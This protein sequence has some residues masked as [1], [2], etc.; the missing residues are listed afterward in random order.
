MALRRRGANGDGLNAWPG[1]VDAL[2]TLLMVI[3]F[4]LL[5][6]V[7]AQAFLSVALSGRDQALD[8]LNRQVA[9]LSDMLSLERGRTSELQLSLA[10]VNNDLASVASARDALAQQVAALRRDQD[11]LAADRDALRT[12]RDRLSAKLADAALQSQTAQ[13]RIEDLTGQLA[14]A[15]KRA[16]TQSLDVSGQLG[17]AR[18]QLTARTA[19][20]ADAKRQLQAAQAQL[21]E[22]QRQMAELDRTVKADKATIEAKLSDLAK[23][24]EQIRTLTA[25]RDDLE[26]QAAAAAAR[27]TTEAQQRAAVAAQLDEEKKLGD[28]AKARIALLSR[29]VDEL[30]AQLASIQKALDASESAGKE[31]DA[32]ITDLGNRLNTALARKVEEL[33]R[34]RS[35]FF[36]RLRAVL[37]NRPGIQVVGDRFVF[38]SEVL[39]PVAS[40]DLTPAGVEQISKLAD[41][42]KQISAEI[43]ADVNWVLRVD[44][45]A[46]RQKIENSRWGSNWELSAGRAITVV[47]LLIADGIPPTRL[48]ATA[49]G[50]NQPLDPANT[51]DAYA[52]NRR[53]EIRLT[54]R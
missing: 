10:Q 8:R 33:Q 41:T 6:F 12:D 47:K 2:S 11:Q 50:E 36:G 42:L 9:E 48:A 13:A 22:M 46:D 7:L 1:Y 38:Q 45:H 54:D 25:L 44:G 53:I 27:A 31:K 51:P 15:A 29:Q 24:T 28:S 23:L 17:E 39:F 14:E 21:E 20:L 43:P 4:V 18:R 5:V 16:D 26:K 34:Y 37:A 3:I 19:E 40:A 32:R 30:R 35:D 49:F 52:K